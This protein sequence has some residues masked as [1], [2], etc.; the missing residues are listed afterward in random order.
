MSRKILRNAYAE[1]DERNSKGTYHYYDPIN[2][3]VTKWN[4]ANKS[5]IKKKENQ[6]SWSMAA[7]IIGGFTLVGVIM[8][9]IKI[10]SDYPEELDST[11][12]YIGYVT[13]R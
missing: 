7:A 12:K 3:P 2:D 11:R 10:R 4:E 9:Y 6:N 8:I 5:T 13:E 1:M